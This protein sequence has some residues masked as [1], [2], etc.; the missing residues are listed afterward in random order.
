MDRGELIELA[1][2]MIQCQGT[3]EEI[4]EWCNLFN[5][6]VPHP[7]GANLFYYPEGYNSRKDDI[8]MYNPSLEEV[9]DRCISY[10]PFQL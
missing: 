7:T 2:K 5:K 1:A 4:D 9:V 3:E 8:S 6:N 10:K